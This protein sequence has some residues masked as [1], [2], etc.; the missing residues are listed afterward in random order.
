MVGNDE[1]R[2]TTMAEKLNIE[3]PVADKWISSDKIKPNRDN[4]RIIFNQKKLDDLKKSIF[5]LG[6]LQPLVVFKESE[7]LD[8]YILIDGERRWRCARELNM[9]Q[10]PVFVH[11]RPTRLQNITSMF[12]IH[13]LRVDWEPMPT[14][15]KL[16]ELM[17]LTGETRNAE[18]ARMCGMAESQVESGKR[19]LFFSNKHRDMVLNHEIK[20][21]FL[22]ELYPF[23]RMLNRKF[24]NLFDRYGTDKIVDL[25]IDKYKLGHVK[26]VTEFRLLSK[27][28]SS[29]DHGAARENVEES[30]QR[31]FNEPDYSIETAYDSIRALFDVGD[32][33]KRCQRLADDLLGFQPHGVD[34][35]ELKTFI[36]ALRKISQALSEIQQRVE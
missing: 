24:P 10:V 27:I 22:V 7:D 12:N 13:K 33:T 18:L 21:N 15:M 32:L 5:E 3:R 2:K 26:A 8:T 19:L 29:V 1:R 14:A 28:V 16:S 23:M 11:G 17:D 31:I 4:P 34:P 36:K 9:S 20:D 30:I 35:D 6:I 25:L